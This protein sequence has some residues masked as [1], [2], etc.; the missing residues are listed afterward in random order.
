LTSSPGKLFVFGLGYSAERLGLRLLADGWSVAGTTRSAESRDRLRALGFTASLHGDD[1]GAAIREATH[2]IG[3]CPPG[4]E[5][6]P[7]LLAYGAALA[8]RSADAPWAGYLSTTGVYGDQDGGVVTEDTPLAPTGERGRRRVLAEAAWAEAL[9]GCRMFRLSGIYGRGRSPFDRLKGPGARRIVKPG[10]RFNRIHVDDIVETLVRAFDHAPPGAAYNLADDL[11]AESSEVLE[12]A[13]RLLG[14]DPPP[15]VAFADAE[16]SPMARSFYAENK[17]VANERIK[18]ELGVRL[19][20]P[21][22][23]EG[24][25]AILADYSAG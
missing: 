22:Y 7:A 10:H 12:E 23:R 16:L 17:I 9:P 13:A 19:A 6:D 1:L 4:P 24:L 5:G 18:R 8:G 21:T 25:R 20:Y 15:A 14:R 11:P 3:S 2:I